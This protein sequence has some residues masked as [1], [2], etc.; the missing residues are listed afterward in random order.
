[1]PITT[2]AFDRYVILGMAKSIMY[3]PNAYC[4][5]KEISID[6]SAMAKAFSI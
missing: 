1:M 3:G 4:E 6:V 2:I 5:Q